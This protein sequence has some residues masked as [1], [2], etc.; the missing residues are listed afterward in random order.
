[1]WMFLVIVEISYFDFVNGLFIIVR[2]GF[3]RCE[4]LVVDFVRVFFCM[5]VKCVCVFIC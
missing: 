3:I 4:V 5:Y 2:F 1:M